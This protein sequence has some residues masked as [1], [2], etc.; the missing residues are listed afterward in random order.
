MKNPVARRYADALHALAKD[1]NLR[2]KVLRQ[3]EATAKAWQDSSEF[4]IL[5]T[6]PRVSLDASARFCRSWQRA[7]SLR[8]AWLICST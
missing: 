7:L 5:M 8:I 4:R 1:G 3:L 2:Q 6:N